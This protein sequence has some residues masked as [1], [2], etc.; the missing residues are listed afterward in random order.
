[1]RDVTTARMRFMRQQGDSVGGDNYLPYDDV[2]RLARKFLRSI[3]RQNFLQARAI[4]AT[5]DSLGFD[6]E[7]S[8]DPEAA[9]G[10]AAAGAQPVQDLLGRRRLPLLER[11]RRTAHA[12][13]QLPARARRATADL[14]HFAAG[15]AVRGVRDLH[16]PR[17]AAA[18]VAQAVP[19]GRGRP[20]LEPRPVRGQ[21]PGLRRPGAALVRGRQSRRPARD[22]VVPP[23][24]GR[25]VLRHPLG[26]AADRQRVPVHRATRGF[27]AA[28]RAH[29]AGSGRD[30]APVRDAPGLARTR[31]GE[32][33]PA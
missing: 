3:G 20:L 13:R 2:G 5:L 32:V 7:V 9:R 30:A 11:R 33:L 29:R 26:R 28:R 22:R 6:T 31:T 16:H 18:R 24:G 12:G 19:H 27:R 1:M 17:L 10:R 15:V 21:R 4:E 14:V 25:H 23:G 8:V